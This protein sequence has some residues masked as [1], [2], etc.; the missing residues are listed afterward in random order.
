MKIKFNKTK[1]VSD[2]E[3]VVSEPRQVRPERLDRLYDDPRMFLKK[4][5][6]VIEFSRNLMD[7]I[8]GLHEDLI[9]AGPLGGEHHDRLHRLRR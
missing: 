1:R 6:D 4:K 8:V 9:H 5:L 2:P 3:T 7:N